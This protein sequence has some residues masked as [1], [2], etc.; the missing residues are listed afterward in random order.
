VKSSTNCQPPTSM[1][2]GDSQAGAGSNNVTAGELHVQVSVRFSDEL[3]DAMMKRRVGALREK[4][5]LRDTREWWIPGQP[6]LTAR[7]KLVDP[8]LNAVHHYNEIKPQLLTTG[9]TSDGRFLARM[10][11]QVVGL[12]P[13]NATIHKINECVKA[14]ALQLL[15]R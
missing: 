4:Y 5:Q 14:S 9:G 6:F 10:G 13:V 1:Q 7:G 3:N 8:V 15:A 11:A 12:G 2:V